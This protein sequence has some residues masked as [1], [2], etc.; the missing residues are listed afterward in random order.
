MTAPLYLLVRHNG[1]ALR[2]ARWHD[3]TLGIWS[4]FV[5]HFVFALPVGLVTRVNLNFMLCPTPALDELLAGVF[6]PSHTELWPSYH[7]P[8]TLGVPVI[9]QVV[10]MVYIAAAVVVHKALDLFTARKTNRKKTS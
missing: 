8:V 2:A 1:A 9:A 6:G 3:A 7:T 4:M 5:Y 10:A